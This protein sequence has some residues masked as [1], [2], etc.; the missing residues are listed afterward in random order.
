MVRLFA[1]ILESKQGHAMLSRK[2]GIRSIVGDMLKD[3][4]WVHHVAKSST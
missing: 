1:T 4:I 2:L 3:G